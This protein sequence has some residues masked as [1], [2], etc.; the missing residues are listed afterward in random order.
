M[1]RH[2]YGAS[3]V[4]RVRFDRF[5]RLGLSVVEFCSRE[6]VSVASFYYWR[7]KLEAEGQRGRSEAPRRRRSGAP[8]FQP[9]TVVAAPAVSIHL[10]GGAR[11]EVRAE[12]LDAVRA[13]IAEVARVDAGRPH[14]GAGSIREAGA[15]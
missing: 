6:G 11:I 9:V 5:A 3:R 10:P 13:V 14:D 15:C 1:S 7:K 8:A 2:S 12:E 4:W